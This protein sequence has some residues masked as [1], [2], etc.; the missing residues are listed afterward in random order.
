MWDKEI[1][2]IPLENSGE[3][4]LHKIYWVFT[5]C[6]TKHCAE[7]FTWINLI[8]EV[9]CLLNIYIRHFIFGLFTYLLSISFTYRTA[10]S[11]SLVLTNRVPVL[12][13]T[14]NVCW[15]NKLTNQWKKTGPAGKD[16]WLFYQVFLIDGSISG[17]HSFLICP[18]A[19]RLLLTLIALSLD[20]CS[21]I[22]IFMWL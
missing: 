22:I 15:I 1:F 8:H 13:I 17:I 21:H 9:H 20:C 4:R 12:H 16:L 19:T 2:K 6:N 10:R 5:I 11:I 14:V 7:C 18:I 3:D